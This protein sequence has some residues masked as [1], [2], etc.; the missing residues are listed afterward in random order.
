[1][2]IGNRGRNAQDMT[3]ECIHS[4]VSNQWCEFPAGYTLAAGASVRVHSSPGA[5]S[6]SPTDL[7]C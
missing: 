6:S 1:M 3:K 5:G 2:M 7:L 4:V